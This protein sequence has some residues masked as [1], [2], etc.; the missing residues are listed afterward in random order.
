MGLLFLGRTAAFAF[1]F[2]L[3]LVLAR[4][5]SQEDFGLYR[6]LFLIHSTV[7]AILTFGFSAS[8][9]YF[10]PRCEGHE[11]R[12][13]IAQTLLILAGFG[14]VGAWFLAAFRGQIAEVLNSPKLG[15]YLPY[16]A[17]FTMLSLVASVLETLMVTLKQAA[18]AAVT[19]LASE[20]VRAALIIGVSVA[21]RSMLALVLAALVWSGGRVLALLLYVRGLEVLWWIP[22]DPSRLAKQ[23]RYAVPFG[24]AL[25]AWTLATN[26]HQYAVSSLSDPALFAIY[27]VGCLQMP[28]IAVV[29]ES[30]CDVTLVRVT[31]LWKDHL[32]DEAVWVIGEAVTKLALVFLPMYVWLTVHARDV[33]VLL[34]TDRF[35][36]SADI[37]QIF[38]ALV[39]LATLDLD[40]VPR[41]F[42]DTW[43]VLRV[44]LFRL[45]LC[46]AFLA[47]LVTPLGLIGAAL[48]T[49]LGFG[50]SRVVTLHKLAAL[51]KRPVGRLLPW[52]NLGRILAAAL[53]STA[54]AWGVTVAW[55]VTPALRLAGS[56][57]LFGACYGVLVWSGGVLTPDEKR[58]VAE[59]L[60]RLTG[61]ASAWFPMKA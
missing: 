56:G 52:R 43:Y 8:L 25:V 13:Y 48:S 50:L 3:P 27:S 15:E 49:V 22:P 36:A 5:F 59:T 32:L 45:I 61:A 18:W 28:F 14:M 21:T 39:A 4:V 57:V 17:A 23:I 11:R 54:V 29:F 26:L 42:A 20:F 53:L 10:V 2:A 51:L 37:F 41:A 9:Y 40:Y 58:R 12:A 35:E 44:N 19:N 60:R 24:F 34:Y 30:V 6:Q 38:V 55:P 46:A 7:M 16:L 31:E 1:V 33:I 47:V